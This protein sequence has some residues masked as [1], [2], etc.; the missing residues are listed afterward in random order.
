MRAT[1]DHSCR[2]LVACPDSNRGL[3]GLGSGGSIPPSGRPVSPFAGVHA[4]AWRV[5]FNRSSPWTRGLIAGSAAPRGFEPP[6]V[7]LTGRCSAV[8]L[9]GTV[10]PGPLLR[11]RG[12]VPLIHATRSTEVVRHAS[13]VTVPGDTG[14]CPGRIRTSDLR[15]ISATLS[16]TE[17]QGT[18]GLVPPPGLEPGPTARQ[19]G[20]LTLDTMRGCP[21]AGTGRHRASLRRAAPQAFDPD[22]RVVHGTNRPEPPVPPFCRWSDAHREGARPGH[23]RCTSVRL[24]RVETRGFEPP[25]RRSVLCPLSYVPKRRE[26]EFHRLLP[27]GSARCESGLLREGCTSHRPTGVSAVPHRVG[28]VT[29]SRRVDSN[30]R[31]AGL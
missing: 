13:G 20:V 10:V 27:P 24:V 1:S 14:R 2:A 26:S 12:A 3:S 7:A 5:G 4:R 8:E 9:R 25:P 11:E 21:P 18:T 16:P 15:V 19:A 22:G 17:L 31:L 6:T 29:L 23:I 30:H 28:R